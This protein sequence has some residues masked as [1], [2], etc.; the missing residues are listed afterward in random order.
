MASVGAIGCF[1]LSAASY[2]PFIWVALWILPRTRSRPA[3]E[4]SFDRRELV[5]GLRKIAGAHDLS[6]ALLTV[7]LTSTL[8]G[9][10]IVF[11]PV[12]VKNALGRGVGDFSMAVAA[13][14]IG[15]LC[16]AVGL[17]GVRAGAD[18]R[19]ISS[20][21]ARG[22]GALVILIALCPWFDAL[23]GL[24]AL[25]GLSMTISNT[26]ANALLQ[27]SAPL[28]LRGQT[29][30]LYMLAMRGGLSIGSLLT[31]LAVHALGVREALLINGTL[32]LTAQAAI[33]WR[34]LRAA[35]G[36]TM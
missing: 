15:G 16:G 9:P 10:L 32:A 23:P 26:S 4:A 13:F 21:F 30:S 19:R 1:A 14:G 6:G 12:L 24:L 35:H 29:V 8:C 22:Y 11:C 36:R 34:W 7:L 17:L 33:G 27:S 18:R 5:A 2:V 25:A 3:T 28:E 31:G 20:W